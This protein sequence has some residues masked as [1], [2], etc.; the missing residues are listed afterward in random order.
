MENTYGYIRTSRQRI[1]GEAGSDPEAPA[2]QLRGAGVAPED[3]YRDVGVS[4]SIGT[5]SRASWH[6]LNTRLTSGDTLVVAAIDRIGRRWMGHGECGAGFADPGSQDTV[7]LRRGGFLGVLPGGRPRHAG[8]LSGGHPVEF[9]GWASEQ[10]LEATRRRTVVGLD[11][12]RVEGKTLGPPRKLD[13]DQV[14]TARR[15]RREKVSLR[16]IGRQFKVSAS[17]VDRYLKKEELAS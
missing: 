6:T 12:A 14:E 15:R 3:I 17:T 16:E 8:D 10:E 1:A 2:L 11:K 13:S 7:P 5:N 9:Y 4:G